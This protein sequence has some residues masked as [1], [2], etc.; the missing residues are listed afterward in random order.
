LTQTATSFGQ[1][2]D[3]LSYFR[4]AYDDFADYRAV[5]DRLTGLLDADEASRSLPVLAHATGEELDIRGLTV[6]RPD[7]RLLIEE[8]RLT[9]RPGEALLVSGASGSGKTTLLR[10]LA[11]LWPYADGAVTRPA[12]S[13][14]MFLSQQPYLPLGSLRAALAYPEPGDL[15]TDELA[16]AVLTQVQLRHLVGRL[17]EASGWTRTLSPGEQP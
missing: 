17:D 7:G 10:S 6:T 3:S 11:G 1:V 2:H 4:N 15:L 9:A 8:L 5:L 14:A 16:T 12:D 13:E